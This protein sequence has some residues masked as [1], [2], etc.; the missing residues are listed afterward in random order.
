MAKFTVTLEGERDVK[1][2]LRRFEKRAERAIWAGIQRTTFEALNEARDK[3]PKDTSTLERS[4]SPEF[5]RKRLEAFV[6]T[7]VEYAKTVEFGFEGTQSVQSHSRL[8][9][10]A[11]GRRITPVKATVRAHSRNVVRTPSP[12]MEPAAALAKRRLLRNVR[13][14]L[15]V[16]T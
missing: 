12:Y 15:E 4:I 8:I 1:R 16:I 14:E 3:V 5:D 7:N 9:T 6:F 2:A 13:A 11:Y 10:Q